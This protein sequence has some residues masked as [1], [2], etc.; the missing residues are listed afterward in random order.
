M[1][2]VLDHFD[3]LYGSTSSHAVIEMTATPEQGT[4]TRTLESWSRGED[5]DSS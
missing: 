2:E 5:E 4:R 3:E 1:D